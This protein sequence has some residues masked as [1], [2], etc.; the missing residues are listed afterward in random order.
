MQTIYFAIL[1]LVSL[2]LS[3][4]EGQT[5]TRS[6]S[7]Q[8]FFIPDGPPLTTSD[9]QE[10]IKYYGAFFIVPIVLGILL[11]I[12]LTFLNCVTCFCPK[13]CC[14]PPCCLD[15]KTAIG[16]LYTFGFLVIVGG[17]ISAWY[18]APL[19]TEGVDIIFN[20][21]S[22]VVD[23]IVDFLKGVKDSI[24]NLSS[25]LENVL[26]PAFNG[27]ALNNTS[28]DIHSKIND[29][30]NQ[31]IQVNNSVAALQQYYNQVRAQLLIIDQAK[32]DAGITYNTPSASSV[33]DPMASTGFDIDIFESFLDKIENETDKIDAQVNSAK[34]TNNPN[35]PPE[36]RTFPNFT[37][38]FNYSQIIEKIDFELNRILEVTG[39]SDPLNALNNT[40]FSSIPF[41][42]SDF[43]EISQ[44][45]DENGGVYT[46]I[47]CAIGVSIVLAYLLWYLGLCTLA[48]IHRVPFCWSSFIIIFLGLAV[49][50][51]LLF[52][53]VTDSFCTYR[54]ELITLAANRTLEVAREQNFPPASM[55]LL[56]K[57]LYDPQLLFECHDN[58]TIFELYNIDL[59][60]DLGFADQIEAL[61]NGTSLNIFPNSTSIDQGM[62]DL[63]DK[64][65]KYSNISNS[66][67]SQLQQNKDSLIGF[68]QYLFN[69][70]IFA[71]CIPQPS[72]PPP[73][74]SI[75]TCENSTQNILNLID[76]INA[77]LT[78]LNSQIAGLRTTLDNLAA[79][80]RNII[81]IIKDT[82]KFPDLDPDI[83]SSILHAL[84]ECGWLGGFWQNIVGV[85]LCEKISPSVL[86]V[87]WSFAVVGIA[88]IFLTPIIIWSL[89]MDSGIV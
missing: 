37:L 48:V 9:W 63:Y 75:Y 74:D 36:M 66:Y 8:P 42:P 32:A 39:L 52:G 30:R 54:E 47:V 19:F 35:L 77:T 82:L 2:L 57:I 40:L 62:Q 4:T 51:H 76:Q 68:Q 24:S 3:E 79:L 26:T 7:S 73:C 22:G 53:S 6:N 28:Q 89:N 12:F 41:T 18:H 58:Q 78:N 16:F 15:S 29:T 11:S 13:C 59:W 43:E 1:L 87:G 61:L 80:R 67:Y 72:P 83:G 50:V 17:C 23:D 5:F 65:T 60:K 86:W 56:E 34:P 49:G 69:A 70:S 33:P 10:L 14:A 44:V 38:P 25:D 27:T 45:I 85:A 55:K 71:G 20:G 21:I 84:G 31:L 64:Q 81:D 88:M 46:L